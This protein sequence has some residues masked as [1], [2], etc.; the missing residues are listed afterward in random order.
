ML[1]EDPL[2]EHVLETP[3]S[4]HISIIILVQDEYSSLQNSQWRKR[5]TLDQVDYP[6]LPLI[7]LPR[8]LRWSCRKLCSMIWVDS[9]RSAEHVPSSRPTL[10]RYGSIGLRAIPMWRI[11]SLLAVEQS[12][13][14]PTPLWKTLHHNH[15]NLELLSLPMSSRVLC[16]SSEVNGAMRFCCWSSVNTDSS[17]NNLLSN[18]VQ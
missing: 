10:V 15:S 2:L 13:L 17:P 18:F 14:C 12:S 8:P 3:S 16:I 5:T 7:L 9:P 6:S 4:R 11:Q 1:Y